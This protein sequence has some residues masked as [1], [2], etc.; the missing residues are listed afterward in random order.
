M[1]YGTGFVID[2]VFHFFNACV[3]LPDRG[4]RGLGQAHW[5]GLPPHTYPHASL[6]SCPPH[7]YHRGERREEVNVGLLVARTCRAWST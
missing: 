5:P 3:H 2:W 7:T 6:T 4:P 1:A